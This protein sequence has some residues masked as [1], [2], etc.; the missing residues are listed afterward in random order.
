MSN[1]KVTKTYYTGL[2]YYQLVDS[3][4]PSQENP[5]CTVKK[6][7][8]KP[9]FSRISNYFATIAINCFAV[10]DEDKQCKNEIIDVKINNK[11][12]NKHNR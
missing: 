4:P 3:P 11:N 6:Y 7:P 9:S 2:D 10:F 1:D 12:C 5:A 8:D